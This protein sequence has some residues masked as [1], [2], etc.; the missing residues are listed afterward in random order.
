MRNKCFLYKDVVL[1]QLWVKLVLSGSLMQ[2]IF[3]QVSWR[4]RGESGV[5]WGKV[6]NSLT[7]VYTRMN[8][9]SF[10]IMP[11]L[12]LP[13]LD[14][15]LCKKFFVTWSSFIALLRTLFI[16]LLAW[17][18]SKVCIAPQNSSVFICILKQKEVSKLAIKSNRYAVML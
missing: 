15:H 7:L 16:A 17:K 13:S 1:F 6:A 11:L 18:P 14:L 12:H 4:R 5:T 9:L 3:S 8:Q 2:W 10:S